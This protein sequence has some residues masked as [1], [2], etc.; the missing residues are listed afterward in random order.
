M[1]TLSEYLQ[2]FNIHQGLIIQGYI[3]SQIMGTE[4]SVTRYR[5]YKYD[6]TLIFEPHQLHT[7]PQNLIQ[8]LDAYTNSPK[9]VY[10]EYGNPYQCNFGQPYIAHISSDVVIIKTVGH[11]HRVFSR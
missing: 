2:G 5:E 10:T 9:I 8:G 11:S 7:K 6:I 4:H 1:P 3:L